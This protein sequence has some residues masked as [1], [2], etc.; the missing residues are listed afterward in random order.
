MKIKLVNDNITSDYTKN[1]LR[2]TG[3]DNVDEFLLPSEKN[4]QSWEDLDNIKLGVD[5]VDRVTQ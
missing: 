4:L 1:L 5:L 2:S 3:V